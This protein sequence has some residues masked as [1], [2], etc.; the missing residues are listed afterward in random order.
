M[1]INEITSMGR[2]LLNPAGDAQNT[3]DTHG[4]RIETA[5]GEQETAAENL[6]GPTVSEHIEEITRE[7]M[8]EL[9]EAVELLE[10][11]SAAINYDLEF[12]IL[13]SENVIQ[14]RM[15]EG[16]TD[17]IIREIP[18][19][20]VLERRKRMLTFIGLLIDTYR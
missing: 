3:H 12:T 5:A 20:E 9:E 11:V 1:E 17:E 8:A 6:A 16:G 2:E 7:N 19:T 18:P 10:H 4:D 13:P 15:L 14:A